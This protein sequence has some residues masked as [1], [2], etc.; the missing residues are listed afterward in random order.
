MK[1]YEKCIQLEDNLFDVPVAF[2]T[3]LTFFRMF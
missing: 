1:I 3:H 2:R